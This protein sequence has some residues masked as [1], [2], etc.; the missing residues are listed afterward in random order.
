MNGTAPMVTG[1][2]AIFK[3]RIPEGSEGN[4]EKFELYASTQH[5]EAVHGSSIDFGGIVAD[6]EWH[7]MVVDLTAIGT[8]T[9]D[10]DGEYRAKH[11]RLDI[12]NKKMDDTFFID[13][14]YVAMHNDLDYVMEF[15]SNEDVTFIG[16]G[17][18]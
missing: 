6:G 15:L 3:Y 16:A 8:F 14:A 10:D 2:Y 1:Q 7:V 13:V 9:P 4:F 11:L 5:S 12:I 17:E 18:T